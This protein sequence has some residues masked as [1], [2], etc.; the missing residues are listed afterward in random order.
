MFLNIPDSSPEWSSDDAATL[1]AFV[2]GPTGAKLLILL[3]MGAPSLMDG[4]H[5]NKTLV[6]SG[7]VAGYTAALSNL[8]ALQTSRPVES[9]GAAEA[10]PDLDNDRLW[11]DTEPTPVQQT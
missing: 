2:E 9:T 8:L 10:Y 5:V 4:S 7:E 6:R 1:R 3:G 11:N